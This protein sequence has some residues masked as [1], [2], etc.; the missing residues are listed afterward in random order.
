[1]FDLKDRFDGAVKT[2]AFAAAAGAAGVA[3]LF[4]FLVALFL[5]AQ[6]QYGTIT[7]TLVLAIVFL[8][9]ALAALTVVW[10]LRQRAAERERQRAQRAR[11]SAPQWWADPLVMTTVLDVVK[12]VG[13]KRLVAVLIGACIVGSVLTRSGPQ[14]PADPKS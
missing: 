10:I 14:K 9:V 4:F 11:K 6:Q 7:A 13:N 8:V 2:V 5:W 12:T 1:M 3:A